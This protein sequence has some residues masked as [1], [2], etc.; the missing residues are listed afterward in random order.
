MVKPELMHLFVLRMASLQQNLVIMSHCKARFEA[1]RLTYVCLQ[2]KAAPR[3]PDNI[4]HR[5][6]LE[7]FSLLQD[8]QDLLV[9]AIDTLSGYVTMQNGVT[10]SPLV[11][12]TLSLV[13]AG[14]FRTH[15]AEFANLNVIDSRSGDKAR[16]PL[17]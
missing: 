17:C 16:K 2:K 12:T 13:N 11:N 5:Q 1:Y 6:L 10:G 14:T 15:F 9:I 7:N 8:G 3:V 4:Y